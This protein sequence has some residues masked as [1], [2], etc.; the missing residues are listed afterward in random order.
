MGERY[1]STQVLLPEFSKKEPELPEILHSGI[2]FSYPVD[3]IIPEVREF[4]AKH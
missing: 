1:S 3:G 4:F 2:V